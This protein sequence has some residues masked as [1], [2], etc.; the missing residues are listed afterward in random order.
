MP[1]RTDLPAT[2]A[3]VSPTAAPSLSVPDRWSRGPDAPIALT[4]I[5]ATA[6]DGRLWVAAASTPRGPRRIGS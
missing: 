3:T 5:A 4:E 6:H 1:S 2:A